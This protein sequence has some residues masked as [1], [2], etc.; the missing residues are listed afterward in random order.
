VVKELRPTGEGRW[1]DVHVVVVGAG[2]VG[3]ALALAAVDRGHTVAQLD[4][5]PEPRGASVRNFGLC[6]IAGRA[7]GRAPAVGF[8][9]CGALVCAH[10]PAELALLEAACSA[11][12]A[13]ERG[14]RLLRPAEARALEPA[15]GGPL[16][17]ALLSP[18]DATVEPTAALPALRVLA[19]ASGRYAAHLGRAVVEVE[20]G[21]VVDHLGGVHEGDVVLVA[22]GRAVELGDPEGLDGARTEIVRLQMLELATAGPAPRVALAGGGSLRYYPAFDLPERAE[23]PEPGELA[24]RYRLQL[25]TATR[26]S[27]RMTVGDTH[28][29]DEPGVFGL[30]AAPEDELLATLGAWFGS[31][32]GRVVR[33]WTGTYLKRVDGG[34]AYLRARRPDGAFTITATGGHGMTG[35]HAIAAESLDALGF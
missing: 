35:A 15:L 25:L 9:A 22:T 31:A 1:C 24:A 11:P 29:A 16:L 33:R 27:G 18:Y 23:L 12:G 21:R 7:A 26:T 17:G 34:E 4:R 13:A 5:E 8:R 2:V 19:A 20:A 28:T 14:F 30:D 10:H 6:W 3:S 32:P